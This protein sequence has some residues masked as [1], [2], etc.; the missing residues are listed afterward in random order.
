MSYETFARARMRVRVLGF[1][2]PQD[3][4]RTIKILIVHGL[5]DMHD[6]TAV[7]RPRVTID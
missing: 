3:Q 6:A 1:E 7:A 2:R 4:Q 5:I